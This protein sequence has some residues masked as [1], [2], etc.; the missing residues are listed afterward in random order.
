[1][2]QRSYK[3]LQFEMIIHV[4]EQMAEDGLRLAIASIV[5][6]KM[7][8][9]HFDS[10]IMLVNCIKYF[11]LYYTI[12]TYIILYFQFDKIREDNGCFPART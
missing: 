2:S 9:T 10:L 6:S 12:I 1:M 7:L 3:V 8:K 5:S 4:T 11:I